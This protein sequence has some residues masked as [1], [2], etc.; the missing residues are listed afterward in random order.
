MEPF[1]A[2]PARGYRLNRYVFAAEIHHLDGMPMYLRTHIDGVAYVYYCNDGET[3]ESATDRLYDG[4]GGASLAEPSLSSD[5]GAK[6]LKRGSH[7]SWISHVS[8]HG[9]VEQARTSSRTCAA[10]LVCPNM[11]VHLRTVP[12][13]VTT[14][15][16]ED[17]N[18][19]AAIANA[20]L[21]RSPSYRAKQQTL[22]FFRS[23]AAMPCPH[24]G[25]SGYGFWAVIGY[26]YTPILRI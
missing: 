18:L 21:E 12:Y 9:K 4:L 17:E 22:S 26:G 14:Y 10:P 2:A 24:Q 20:E 11:H 16:A 8:F 13:A 6:A 19:T 25:L 7:G 23:R 3:A 1:E 5:A 15:D